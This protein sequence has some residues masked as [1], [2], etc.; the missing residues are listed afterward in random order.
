MIAR[1]GREAEAIGAEVIPNLPSA[2]PSATP[3]LAGYEYNYLSNS[4][5]ELEWFADGSADF[6]NVEIHD[7]SGEILCPLSLI[8]EN[9]QSNTI[10]AASMHL[11][12]SSLD[13]RSS[14]ILSSGSANFGSRV[15]HS[16]VLLDWDW[17]SI[18]FVEI[19]KVRGSIIRRNTSFYAQIS[20]TTLSFDLVLVIRLSCNILSVLVP[21]IM[22]LQH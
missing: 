20:T 10:A 4:T 18:W 22:I 14:G 13:Y 19:S 6:Q 2:S 15:Q 1:S 7:R 3:P 17:Y 12:T 21:P 9:Y 11:Q 5:A 8:I 16:G